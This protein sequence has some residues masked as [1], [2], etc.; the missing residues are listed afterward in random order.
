MY[1]SDR[2]RWTPPIEVRPTEGQIEDL[3]GEIN[4]TTAKGFRTLI[5]TL[6]KKMSEDLTDYL[7][8]LGNRV[9]YLHS[10]IETIERGGDP[11]PAAAGELRCSG[12]EL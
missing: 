4:R 8:N 9:R 10:E 2:I 1:P 5:T 7:A 12:G 3:F 6:T 11:D